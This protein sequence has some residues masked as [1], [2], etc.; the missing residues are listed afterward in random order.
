LRIILYSLSSSCARMPARSIV[1]NATAQWWFSRTLRK[2]YHRA[3]VPTRQSFG[4]TSSR[5]HLVSL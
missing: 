5:S 3:L 4:V 1:S 2:Q